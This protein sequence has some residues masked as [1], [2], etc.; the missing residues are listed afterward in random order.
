MEFY[1]NICRGFNSL[2]FLAQMFNFDENLL[3]YY[4]FTKLYVITTYVVAG[5]LLLQ[6]LVRINVATN[7][8][9]PYKSC[10]YRI[11][12]PWP[13]LPRVYIA[14]LRKR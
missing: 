3:I 6:D 10:S 4:F 13:D 9:E 1:F 11:A 14:G 5:P 12:Y 7:V 2:L 8:A